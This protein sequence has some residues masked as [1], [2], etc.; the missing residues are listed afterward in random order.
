MIE[1]IKPKLSD[2]FYKQFL[3]SG[4]ENFHNFYK[5]YK[6]EFMVYGCKGICMECNSQVLGIGIGLEIE[7]SEI[8]IKGLLNESFLDEI[9]FSG[10]SDHQPDLTDFSITSVPR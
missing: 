5:N 6:K 9:V 2:Y 1:G 8:K 10:W 7:L 3:L 4:Q